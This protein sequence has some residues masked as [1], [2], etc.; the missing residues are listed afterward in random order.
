[1]IPW[2]SNSI[3]CKHC[4]LCNEINKISKL[5]GEKGSGGNVKFYYEVSQHICTSFQ[6]TME[7]GS[8]GEEYRQQVVTVICI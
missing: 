1:M 3:L 6:L 7:A 4:G 5:F 8:G 2:P